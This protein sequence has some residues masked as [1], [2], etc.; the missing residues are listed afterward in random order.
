VRYLESQYAVALAND[1]LNRDG[2]ACRGS[3][4]A[5]VNKFAKEGFRARVDLPDPVPLSDKLKVTCE[6]QSIPKSRSGGQ[7]DPLRS[8]SRAKSQQGPGSAGDLTAS[9]ERRGPSAPVERQR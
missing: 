5:A 4:V 6:R 1:Y 3:T 9:A 8:C 7:N 2:L